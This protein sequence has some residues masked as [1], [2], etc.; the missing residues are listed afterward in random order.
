MAANFGAR[1]EMTQTFQSTHNTLLVLANTQHHTCLRDFDTLF[2]CAFKD[3]QG[4]PEVRSAV[5]YEGRHLL[6]RLH[7]MRIDVKT[8]FCN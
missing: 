7:V 6:S 8:G 2:L 5:T 1:G 3:A 4:L